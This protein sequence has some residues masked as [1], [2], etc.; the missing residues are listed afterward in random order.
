M[1]GHTDG[2][3][4]DKKNLA[5]SDGR[6]K[7]VVAWLVSSG[8]VNAARLVGVGFGETAPIDTNNTEAGR[9]N[10]RRVEFVITP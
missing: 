1:R 4:S 5:L 8:K 3:G 9:A 2:V 10:N 6:A 7:A